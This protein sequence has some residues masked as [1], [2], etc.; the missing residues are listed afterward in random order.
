MASSPPP[1]TRLLWFS[2][3]ASSSCHN[4]CNCDLIFFFIFLTTMTMNGGM[5]EWPPYPQGG[6]WPNTT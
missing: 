5:D 2:I 4:S 6:Q 3:I 1:A